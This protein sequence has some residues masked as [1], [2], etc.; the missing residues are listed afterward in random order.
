MRRFEA[1]R[2]LEDQLR[3]AQAEIAGLRAELASKDLS[4]RTLARE[5]AGVDAALGFA[6]PIGPVE[7]VA[8]AMTASMPPPSE[9]PVETIVETRIAPARSG[10]A[11]KGLG[12]APK[13]G[14]GLAKGAAPERGKSLSELLAPKTGA[15]R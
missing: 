5:L 2:D 12:E 8:E 3:S 6:G 7:S 13:A 9:S 4:I 10:V 14:P 1:Y 11:P 15:K